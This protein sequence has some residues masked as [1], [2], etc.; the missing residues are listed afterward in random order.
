MTELKQA[1][2][3]S[4]LGV[5]AQLTSSFLNGVLSGHFNDIE[6]IITAINDNLYKM[7]QSLVSSDFVGG[8]ELDGTNIKVDASDS[9]SLY[10]GLFYN[11]D[12]GR[13]ATISEVLLSLTEILAYIDNGLREGISIGTIDTKTAITGSSTLS[14]TWPYPDKMFSAKLF[15]LDGPDVKDAVLDGM[16]TIHVN[17]TNIIITNTT[18]STINIWGK[19]W[20]P[21]FNF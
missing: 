4:P 3:F 7:T 14:N 9:G 5:N 17:G 6:N 20:H 12:A 1:T 16:V 19:L 8:K 18:V 15:Y 21:V 10:G 13:A 11:S 2:A